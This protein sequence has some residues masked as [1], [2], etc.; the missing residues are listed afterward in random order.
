MCSPRHAAWYDG[1]VITLIGGYQI[2][3][4][5]F[6]FI[7]REYLYKDLFDPKVT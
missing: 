7:F 3:S 6:I 1:W 4:M 5:Y 2:I